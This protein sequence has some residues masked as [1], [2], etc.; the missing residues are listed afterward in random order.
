[1]PVGRKPK[2]PSVDEG[3]PS[4]RVAGA[5]TPTAAIAALQ[6]DNAQLRA[7]LAAVQAQLNDTQAMAHVGH[8]SYDAATKLLTY[9]PEMCRIFGLPESQPHPRF[10]E[11]S[12]RIHPD[13]RGR[14]LSLLTRTDLEA[15]KHEIAYRVQLSTGEV[16]HV[17]GVGSVVR[18]AA[19]KLLEIRGTTQDITEIVNVRGELIRTEAVLLEAQRLVQIGT[20]FA[21]TINDALHVHWSPTLLELHGLQPDGP[22]P[23]AAEIQGLVHPDDRER[24]ALA[25]QQASQEGSARVE[26]RIVRP[27]GQERYLVTSMSRELRHGNFMLIGSV[28]DV[29]ERKKAELEL[30]QAREL[31]VQASRIKSQ[32]L[33]NMSHEIRT[34]VAGIL[35]MAGL[36]SDSDLNPEQREY[37]DGIVGSAR[38]LLAIVNDVLDLAKIE[39][40]RLEIEAVSFPLATTLAESVSAFRVRAAEKQLDLKLRMDP[41]VPDWIVGDP[42]RLR[43]VISN[44][45]D[46]AVKFTQHGRVT[47]H[48][49]W[50]AGDLRLVVEDTGIGIAPDRT[51]AIFEPFVQA[52]GS[53]TRRF[54]GTGLGLTIVREL[55]QRMGGTV[56]VESETGVG[57]RFIVKMRAP[58]VAAS[59][60]AWRSE[61]NGPQAAALRPLRRLL[62]VEDSAVNAIVMCKWLTK[63]GY[64]VDHVGDGNAAVHAVQAVQ[65]DLVLMDVHM[66]GIDGLEA[67][68]RIR[69]HEA[70]GTHRATILALTANA[71]KGDDVQCIR[72]GM[73]GY[74]SKPV[75][76]DVLARTLERLGGPPQ[77][78]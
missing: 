17:L 45:L 3:G 4:P 27:D 73:D 58:A 10:S 41:S 14:V 67:T 19:G 75:S 61:G 69:E 6:Q 37:V 59:A 16:R 29:T 54:G 34:P 28:Q 72:A 68:Q 46:N 38:N 57:T 35:G 11:Y 21:E 33:A 78:E 39:A 7:K 66:P 22:T 52:D 20:F 30:V 12:A 47:L 13:D 55:V 65:Y 9:S 24:V 60:G 5:D 42:T 18:D 70:S 63:K 40:G 36:A 50:R 56:A 51:A 62:V 48:A 77:P 43:Q 1:M 44:L 64:V 71:M 2:L 53:T 26:Y 49:S 31:A 25:S 23:T 32:F 74:L 76:F 15:A 8:W